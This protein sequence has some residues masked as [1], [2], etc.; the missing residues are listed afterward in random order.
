M[1]ES[2]HGATTILT[3]R[4]QLEVGAEAEVRAPAD[5]LRQ[6]S[7]TSGTES[8]HGAT[9]I[10]TSRSQLEVGVEAEVRA[11]ADPL[12]QNTSTSGSRRL[13]LETGVEIC[14]EV[15]PADGGLKCTLTD[16]FQ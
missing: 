13:P 12:R 7:S 2:A 15:Q 8:A 1:S 16:R 4:S 6:S 10:L 9:T 11:L 14:A 5:P 3:S